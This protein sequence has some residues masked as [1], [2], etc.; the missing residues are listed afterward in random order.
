MGSNLFCHS[1]CYNGFH[2]YRIFGHCAHSNSSG[3]DIIQK[4]YP[5]L[6]GRQECICSSFISDSNANT[7]TVWVSGKKKV[8]LMS[9]GIFYSKSHSFF[10]L[11]IRIWTGG[12]CTIRLALFLYHSD[13]GITTFF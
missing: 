6:I 2:K 11:W 1:S 7:V 13:I 4:K 8:C 12:K 10:H 3:A 9:F 5:C